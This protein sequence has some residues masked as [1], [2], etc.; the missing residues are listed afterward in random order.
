MSIFC[1]ILRTITYTNTIIILE[2]KM[3]RHTLSG[4]GGSGTSSGSVA[5]SNPLVITVSESHSKPGSIALP[6]ESSLDFDAEVSILS[7]TRADCRHVDIASCKTN[8]PLIVAWA[9]VN[10]WGPSNKKAI[11]SQSRSICQASATT[12]NLSPFFAATV[13][14]SGWITRGRVTERT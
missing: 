3:Q 9:W 11:D 8:L 5:T 12:S 7:K 14:I 6:R 10:E 1:M 4:S 13:T 2:L